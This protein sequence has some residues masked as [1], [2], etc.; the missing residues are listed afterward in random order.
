MTNGVRQSKGG[1]LLDLAIARN[2][3][4]WC[5]IINYGVLVLWSV[6]MIVPHEWMHRLANKF[7]RVSADQFDVI[8]L[9]GIVFYKTLIIFFNLVPYIALLIAGLAS[10]YR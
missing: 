3:L 10:E 1:T 8:N 2:M 4:F 7:Y 9:A 5:T 6:L